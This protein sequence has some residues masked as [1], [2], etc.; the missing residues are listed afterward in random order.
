MR[1][2]FTF[3]CT[4]SKIVN[5]YLFNGLIIFFKYFVSSLNKEIPHEIFIDDKESIDNSNF[6]TAHPVKLLIHGFGGSAYDSFP[7]NLR[8]GTQY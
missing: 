7:A 3:C 4:P 8:K 6:D 1:K 2:I 5:F